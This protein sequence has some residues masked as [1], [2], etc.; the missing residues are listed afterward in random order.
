MKVEASLVRPP[1]EAVSVAEPASTP[2]TVFVATPPVAVEEPRPLSV[3]LPEVLAK[4]TE[5][6]LSA[7]R[8]LPAA[9]RI[10]TVRSRV[11]PEARSVTPLV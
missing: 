5:V 2:V 9:S 4:P 3:P 10:S 7:E 1:V 11:A 8:R 6:L